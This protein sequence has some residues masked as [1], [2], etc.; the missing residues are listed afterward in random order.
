MFL[1]SAIEIT[2]AYLAF[3]LPAARVLW[4]QTRDGKKHYGDW[5]N[6]QK[7]LLST[8]VNQ[9]PFVVNVRHSFE[10]ASREVPNNGSET[11]LRE[12]THVVQIGKQVV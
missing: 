9:E 8:S 6:K 2:A 11:E 7:S 4:R 10:V 12:V 1:C 3:W 5:S